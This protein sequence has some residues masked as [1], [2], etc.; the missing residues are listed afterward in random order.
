MS[1]CVV[2]FDGYYKVAGFCT[3][4][5]DGVCGVDYGVEVIEVCAGCGAGTKLFDHMNEGS[6]M[7]V[8]SEETVYD[9]LVL[10][11]FCKV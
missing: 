4:N 9:H 1:L 11:I 7:C 5:G 10:F 3:I 8:V 2:Q 6:V